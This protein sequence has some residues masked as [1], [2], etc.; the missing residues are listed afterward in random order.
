VINECR[1]GTGCPNREA[2]L[3]QDVSVSV[4]LIVG[5]PA[6]DVPLGGLGANE[7]IANYGTAAQRKMHIKQTNCGIL[8]PANRELAID[9]T[10]NQGARQAG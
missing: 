9:R 1:H 4:V 10:A 2:A 8:R 5:C 3:I 6:L 7:A